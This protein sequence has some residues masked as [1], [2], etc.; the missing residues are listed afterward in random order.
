MQRQGRRAVAVFQVVKG[1]RQ[2]IPAGVQAGDLHSRARQFRGDV[3][4]EAP[5]GAGNQGDPSCDLNH[6]GNP[7]SDRGRPMRTS[8]LIYLNS[9]RSPR[10]S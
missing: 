10:R 5:C 3:Q 9:G 4:T 6:Y 7:R 2:L 1:C 8:T